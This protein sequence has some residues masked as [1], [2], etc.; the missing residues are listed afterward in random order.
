[1]A[2]KSSYV[3]VRL[4]AIQKEIEMLRRSLEA[5]EGQRAIKLEGLWKGVEIS[6]EDL[7]KAERSLFKQAHEF[8]E[9]RWRASL[10]MPTL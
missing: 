8:E 9:G 10:S 3:M 1:M 6:D 4:E 7:V 5:A 2:G